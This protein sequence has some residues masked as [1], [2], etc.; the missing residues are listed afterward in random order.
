MNAGAM[1]SATFD[2]LESVRAMDREGLVAVHTASALDPGYRHCGFFDDH[3]ALSAEFR[4]RLAPMAEI[5]ARM[6]AL[7]SKRWESQPAAPSAGCI[8]KN[9]ASIPAGKLIQELG[10]KG[11]RVGGAQISE[12]HGNFF[13][14]DGS[15]KAR[16]V[17][18]L[19]ELVR[20]R[21]LNERQIHL[22]TEV[23]IVGEEE[24]PCE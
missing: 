3:I 1:G 7:S 16:D 4:G 11:T 6:R 14:N 18:S 2:C 17:L 22:Q 21:A 10:L 19:I 23:Q 12:M 5:E 20:E 8:F 24:S 15:A 13:V 9:P